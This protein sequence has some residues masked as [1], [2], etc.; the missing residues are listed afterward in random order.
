MNRYDLA[1]LR[2]LDDFLLQSARFQLPNF[3]DFD[4]WSN[5]IQQNLVYYQ[6]NYFLMMLAIFLLIGTFH[7]SKVILG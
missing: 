5:R 2:S 6:S 7:P 1:P 3:N 4:R